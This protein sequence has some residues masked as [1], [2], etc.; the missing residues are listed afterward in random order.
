MVARS[1]RTTLPSD[2][3]ALASR[4]RTGSGRG[5]PVPPVLGAGRSDSCADPPIVVSV[6]AEAERIVSQAGG[7][8]LLKLVCR[9]DGGI[10]SM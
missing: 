1:F 10:R 5:A 7:S 3:L 6:Q 9:I 4:C 2:P 8:S